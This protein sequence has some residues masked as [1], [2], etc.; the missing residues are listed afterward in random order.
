MTARYPEVVM[1][2][3]LS[4]QQLFTVK[5]AVAV[6]LIWALVIYKVFLISA[7]ATGDERPARIAPSLAARRRPAGSLRLSRERPLAAR[8]AI[9]ELTP[10]LS[11]RD[12][13]LDVGS[14]LGDGVAAVVLA[15]EQSVDPG[16][17]PGSGRIGEGQRH[18]RR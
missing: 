16:L 1:P 6:V 18:P 7:T 3:W 11:G 8:S 12:H 5:L 9:C 2:H 17:P 10:R 4:P 15:R 14:G 13:R